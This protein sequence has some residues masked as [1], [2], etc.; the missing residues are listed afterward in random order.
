MW[1]RI[2]GNKD[3]LEKLNKRLRESTIV[4]RQ[5]GD[6]IYSYAG[7]EAFEILKLQCFTLSCHPYPCTKPEGM[8][9][10]KKE[11]YLMTCGTRIYNPALVNRHYFAC[12]S[13]K[14]AFLGIDAKQKR[15]QEIH[16][17]NNSGDP[18]IIDRERRTGRNGECV[19]VAKLEPGVDHNLAGCIKSLKSMQDQMSECNE[20]Y[21]KLIP[22]LEEYETSFTNICNL[23]KEMVS[24]LNAI[25]LLIREHKLDVPLL[26]LP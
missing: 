22:A 21:G 19:T 25:I 9:T 3:N 18:L 5:Q 24:R 8:N 14:K 15:P 13:C 11:V 7:K 23:H 2:E 17:R 6:Y 12:E 16:K 1:Y 4:S 26:K 20:L 10:P